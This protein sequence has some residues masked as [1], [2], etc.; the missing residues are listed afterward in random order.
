MSANYYRL[1]NHICKEVWLDIR[2]VYYL[3]LSLG[4]LKFLGVSLW[5][6]FGLFFQPLLPCRTLMKLIY[7]HRANVQI[8]ALTSTKT[9]SQ[10]S[11]HIF[12]ESDL[13]AVGKNSVV[14]FRL[15]LV[16]RRFYKN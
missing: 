6:V 10:K 3:Y 2:L 5:D 1:G 9:K 8:K 11:V 4:I 12:I 7:L 15:M 16:F 14:I 13:V